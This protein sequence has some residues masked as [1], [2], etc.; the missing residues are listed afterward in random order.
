MPAPYSP[1]SPDFAPINYYQQWAPYQSYYQ[2][3]YYPPKT[4]DAFYSMQYPEIPHSDFPD[5]DSIQDRF[6]NVHIKD[7]EGD[8]GNAEE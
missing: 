6:E 2:P 5:L 8:G 7:E 1:Y 3:A 4:D